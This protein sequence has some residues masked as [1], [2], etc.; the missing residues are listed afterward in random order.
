[1]DMEVGMPAALEGRVPCCTLWQI[2]TRWVRHRHHRFDPQGLGALFF[3][4]VV[5][6]SA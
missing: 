1:M 3:L 6:Q 2:L 5:L 4:S